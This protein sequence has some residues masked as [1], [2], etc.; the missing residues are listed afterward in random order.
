MNNAGRQRRD[1]LGS[2]EGHF[3]SLPEDEYPNAVRPAGYLTYPDRQGRTFPRPSPSGRPRRRGPDH[4]RSSGTNPRGAW[5]SVVT[6]ADG[7][8]GFDAYADVGLRFAFLLPL[9][10]GLVSAALVVLVL[11]AKLRGFRE[12]SSG[13]R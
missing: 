11:A 4:A 2:G 9:G 3:E 12:A 13:L 1:L 5:S 7:A 6:Q 10:I 8:P